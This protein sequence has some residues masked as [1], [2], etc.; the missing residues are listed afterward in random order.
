MRHHT[1]DKV[2]LHAEHASSKLEQTGSDHTMKAA[3][4]LPS[5]SHSALTDPAKA[6]VPTLP[7]SQP[8]VRHNVSD[9]IMAK[10]IKDS[11]RTAKPDDKIAVD[12]NLLWVTTRCGLRIPM[13]HPETKQ[14]LL[15]VMIGLFFTVLDAFSVPFQLA[16]EKIPEGIVLRSFAN[17]YYLCDI[18]LNFLTGFQ[19]DVGVVHMSPSTVAKTYLSSWFWLDFFASIPWDWIPENDAAALMRPFRCLRALRMMRLARLLRIAKLKAMIGRIEQSIEGN[20]VLIFSVGV[21][22]VV[23]TLFFITHWAAC[24]WWVLGQQNPDNNWFT[25]HVVSSW[26]DGADILSDSNSC[27]LSSLY[28]AMTTMTT[29]GYGDITPTNY[30]EMEFVLVLLCASAI[31]FAGQMGMLSDLI[32]NSNKHQSAIQDKKIT[33]ARYLSW[34]AVPPKLRQNIRQYLVFLWET[35]E[36]NDAYEEELKDMLPTVLRKELCF[37][38]YG[39][40]L[41][42][43]PFLA[44]LRDY[45]VVVKQLSFLAESMFLELGDHL[46]RTGEGCSNIFILLDGVVRISRN[47]KIDLIDV[48]QTK[49]MAIPRKKEQGLVQI[50]R[51]MIHHHSS[52]AKLNA[53][54]V[55]KMQADAAMKFVP[56]SVNKETE[57]EELKETRIN[58]SFLRSH[59][60]DEGVESL[61]NSS[62]I[63]DNAYD[64]L[65]KEDGRQARAAS[66]VQSM[67]RRKKR[68]Q[69]KDSVYDSLSTTGSTKTSGFHANS[70]PTC[71]VPA[72]AY[73]G[74]SCLWTDAQNWLVEEPHQYLY[75]AWCVERS[76][77]VLLPRSAIKEVLDKFSPWLED[78]LKIF[79]ENVRKQFDQS[80]GV[81]GLNEDEE[82]VKA[83]PIIGEASAED[84][85]R[86]DKHFWNTVDV[87]MPPDDSAG[88]LG[89]SP[90]QKQALHRGFT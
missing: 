55:V 2:L 82:T 48:D 54:K 70:L 83:Q 77:V 85:K 28:F 72:P 13:I 43:V 31:V 29:V 52:Q 23:V 81:N 63:Y 75:S 46:F 86:Q 84:R 20:H 44:W 33:L 10:M 68:K 79:Q 1:G 35:N 51:T 62:G 17:L 50:G 40:I 38:I 57:D 58:G 27:W 49:Q 30:G 15:W 66:Y 12:R 25:T 4:P 7:Q 71:S 76:E 41:C 60:Q 14:R 3:L 18:P 45:Q 78:R 37:H 67:W 56:K 74:E 22:R 61:F 89:V 73:F 88:A 47:E 16:F 34:R 26:S 9:D 64:E 53:E 19:D 87:T 21:F 39:G 5:Q 36:G 42:T 32:S 80:H 11:T 65:R 6:S 59:S 69:K 24:Y 90:A 8:S